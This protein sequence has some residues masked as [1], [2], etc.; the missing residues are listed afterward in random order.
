M[1]SVT[2]FVFVFYEST[3]FSCFFFFFFFQA[4]DGIRDKLVTGVQT[5]ALPISRE[6]STPTRIGAMVRGVPANAHR[7]T[8]R[9]G[10]RSRGP[11][12]EVHDP[13]R[14]E[15]EGPGSPRHGAIPRPCP[16]VFA[17]RERLLDRV[18]LPL[19][20]CRIRNPRGKGPRRHPDHADRKPRSS[21][22]AGEQ[23]RRDPPC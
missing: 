21:G 11:R 10:S 4:E 13:A 20:G 1:K 12:V 2:I 18:A 7:G 22:P 19:G 15:L 8:W 14:G 23:G 5:C 16:R 17:R 6:R 9:V 3:G